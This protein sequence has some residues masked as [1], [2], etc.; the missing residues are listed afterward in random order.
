[1]SQMYSTW[2]I[3]LLTY[4][5]MLIHTLQNILI[6]QNVNNEYDIYKIIKIKLNE[7]D[8]LILKTTPNNVYN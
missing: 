8:E 1:M 7:V 2:I 6:E 3:A 5:K 4:N